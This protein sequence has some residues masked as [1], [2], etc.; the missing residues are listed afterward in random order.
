MPSDTPGPRRM[1]WAEYRSRV[2]SLVAQVLEVEGGPIAGP[3]LAEAATLF[4]G[5]SGNVV[6]ALSEP[7]LICPRCG[8]LHHG[9][10]WEPLCYECDKATK[11]AARE[12]AIRADERAKVR[13]EL[14]QKG[15]T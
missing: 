4:G 10:G 8:R 2:T 3:L 1:L 5:Q 15:T 9:C 7:P 12:E 13:A 14:A 11:E 6:S